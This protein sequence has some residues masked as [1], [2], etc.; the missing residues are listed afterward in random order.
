MK[1]RKHLFIILSLFFCL[2]FFCKKIYNNNSLDNYYYK[3]LKFIESRKI[4]KSSIDTEKE[5]ND[6]IDTIELYMH[7]DG[8]NGLEVD[9]IRR[10]AIRAVIVE[11]GQER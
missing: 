10:K 8:Y 2:G 9:E 5:L 7:I 4:R 1:K 11:I 3:Q 6:Y